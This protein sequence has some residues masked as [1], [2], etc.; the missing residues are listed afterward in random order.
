MQQ[1]ELWMQDEIN[2]RRHRQCKQCT[3]IINNEQYEEY[4]EQCGKHS[5]YCSVR[6]LLYYVTLNELLDGVSI[7]E[8]QLQNK[9]TEWLIKLTT[10]YSDLAKL[11]NSQTNS[12]VQELLEACGIL[13]EVIH[14]VNDKRASQVQ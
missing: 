4:R 1:P 14:D 12:Y 8:L 2:E 10:I 6:R 9:E 7:D 11:A 5:Q 3:V 13:W